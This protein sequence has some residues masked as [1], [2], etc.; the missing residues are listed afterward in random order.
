MLNYFHAL[1]LGIVQG[2]TEWLPV[3]SSGHLVL[4]QKYFGLSV[5]VAFDVVLHLGTLLV[6]FIVFWKDILAILKSLFAWRW[7]DNTKL[8]LYL[9]IGSIPIAFVGFFWHDFLVGLFSSVLVVAIGLLVTGTL[10]YFSKL[11]KG[12]DNPNWYKT[13]LI[14]I[15]QSFAIIPGLSRSG[16]TI[17]MGLFLGIDRRKVARFSFLLSIP[18]ILGAT[19]FEFK[20]LVGLEVGPVIFGTVVS[21]F[22]GYF[23][24]KFLLKLV[25]Q[26]R[27]HYFAY[28]CWALGLVLLCLILF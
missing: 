27:F 1:I 16:A 24:L 9:V 10:L 5:P 8:L 15:A 17:S 14:G 7:D 3:S 19:L 25:L 21:I 11:F 23:A 13:F 18:A 2:L 22:V 28:Y 6:V 20:N 4:F 26:N 12:V